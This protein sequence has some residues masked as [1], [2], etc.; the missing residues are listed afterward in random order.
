MDTH[1]GIQNNLTSTS[2]SDSLSAAQGRLLANGS[3]RDSTKL[4]LSGGTLSGSLFIPNNA[5]IIQNQNSTS[6]YTPV[7]KWY[8]GG[9][10]QNTYDPQIGHHSTGGTGTGSIAIL[11]YSTATTPWGGTVG[12]FLTES[13]IKFNNNTI[14]HSGNITPVPT[15]RTITAGNGLTGGGNL[16]A[17]RTLSVNFGSTA[18]TVA[19]GNHTH[20]EYQTNN[21]VYYRTVDS[22]PTSSK[23]WYS[24]FDTSDNRGD[25][26]IICMLSAYAH[27]SMIF[28][29]NRGYAGAITLN[30]L[31]Y[32]GSSNASYGFIDGV[33]VLKTGKVQ[34]RLNKASSINN[35]YVRVNLISSGDNIKP[36]ATLVLD[37]TSSETDVARELFGTNNAI[38][39]EKFI[40]NAS[41]ATS[42]QTA[43]T[44]WGRSFDGTGNVTGNISSTGNI[45]PLATISHNIGTSSLMY[46]RAYIRRID[47]QSGYDL[48]L[49]VAGSERMI[50]NT[51]G[52]VG[53][54][55]TSPAYK[56][57]VSGNIR[58]SGT[59][60]SA[61]GTISSTL[62]STGMFVFEPGSTGG[63][64]EG[65]RFN[66]STSG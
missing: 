32:N 18:T 13:A 52:N 10:S 44:I 66:L 9:V 56:L 61:G 17:N 58:A 15:S 29:V 34:I 26:P 33:R 42:L 53:I 28:S 46:E 57:D 1:R 48:R 27:S 49:N 4:A 40:G 22:L 37:S 36:F 31:N 47:T 16:S 38:T 35:Y 50:I 64:K 43:K 60:T 65:A 20:S 23:G 8:K 45:T 19:K 11:P 39:A 51:S 63:F 24:L 3:A 12:L 7:I 6:N 5:P 55:T 30:I 41:T 25:S 59:I 62:K 21:S 14:Y 2:T 54:G